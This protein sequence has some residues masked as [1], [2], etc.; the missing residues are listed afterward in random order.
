MTFQNCVEN[1]FS[2]YILYPI[3]TLPLCK[4][5]LSIQLS[6][7]NILESNYTTSNS[8]QTKDLNVK[9]AILVLQEGKIEFLNFIF[10]CTRSSLL[11]PGCSLEAANGGFS[12][13]AVRRLLIAVASLVEIGL[14]S[15]Q[16]SVAAAHRLQGTGSIITLR[17]LSCSVAWGT[18]PDQGQNR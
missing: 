1:G 16:A 18:V 10:G 4:E 15:V 5:K 13:A 9:T 8:R 7:K 17:G 3:N 2:P 6:E 12:L 14:Q 11:P